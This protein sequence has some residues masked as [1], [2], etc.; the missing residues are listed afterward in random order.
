MS[1]CNSTSRI[2]KR[3]G[4]YSFRI[5]NFSG[6]STRIGE[7]TESPEVNTSDAMIILFS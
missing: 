1:K 6:M 4:S 7:S 2:S 3:K 5:E